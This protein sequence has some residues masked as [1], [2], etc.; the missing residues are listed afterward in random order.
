MIFFMSEKDY[1]IGNGD[2]PLNIKINEDQTYDLY[3]QN[4]LWKKGFKSVEEVYQYLREKVMERI[5]EFNKNFNKNDYLTIE[6][7]E[8][9]IK[10]EE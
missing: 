1:T 10:K 2:T 8:E 5:E 4:E 9:R 7:I 6:D 3:Y